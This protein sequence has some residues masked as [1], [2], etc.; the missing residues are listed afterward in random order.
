MDG[1]TNF[2]I[3]DISQIASFMICV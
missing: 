2:I 3:W 1:I